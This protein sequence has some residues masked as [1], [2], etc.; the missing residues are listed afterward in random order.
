M[1]L[2]WIAFDADDTL[3]HNETLYHAA[4]E[5]LRQI[6]SPYAPA[7]AVNDAL[8][9]TEMHNLEHFGY[10]IK[11]F[12]LSM[13]ETALRISDNQ[14]PAAQIAKIVA[15]AHEMIAHPVDLLPGVG[16][17]LQRL[18]SSHRLMLITKGDLRDQQSKL[19]RSNLAQFFSRVEILSVKTRAEYAAILARD[20]INPETFLMVGNSLRSDILPVIEMNGWGVF[21]PYPL[22]WAH[23]H[24]EHPAEGHPRLFELDHIALLPALIARIEGK[25]N[26]D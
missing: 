3:W 5:Q 2:D 14:I 17:V 15:I 23:E 11:A 26:Q 24:A 16:E 7:Q 21:I 8:F 22:S 13:V 18:S 9:E 1:K 20:G 12:V 4:Q 6:L 19:H 10:G 25:E